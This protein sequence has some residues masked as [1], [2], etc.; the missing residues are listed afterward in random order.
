MR[1][2]LK[3][4]LGR[5]APTDGDGRAV[6]PPGAASPVSRYRPLA[7]R[8]RSRLT[9]L[10][11]V[12]IWLGAASL[13]LAV[14]TAGGAYLYFHESV[15][16]VAAKSPAVK[17]AAQQLDIPLPGQPAVAL[18][19]GYDRRKGDG[20]DTP[21]RSDTLM[22]VRADPDTDSISL[23]SFPRDLRADIRCPGRTPYS[24]KIAHAY[25][26]CGPQG[27]LQTVRALTGI[28]IN[29][30]ITVNFRGFREIVDRMGERGST[31]TGGTSTTAVGR[32]DTPRSTSD[33]GISSSRGAAPSTTCAT[34][35]PTP[36]ST[37][38]RASSSS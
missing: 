38:W 19:I 7:P 14:G 25:M 31:S 1:T 3:K 11:Q 21:S 4:G 23:L 22:L 35:T 18:V 26:E 5:S 12:A 10:V 13:V 32:R 24:D 16:S 8:G 36:T 27:S 33:P 37:A 29:Y 28:P 34:G 30:L 6:F 15:A 20:A 9:L 2:T 17:R